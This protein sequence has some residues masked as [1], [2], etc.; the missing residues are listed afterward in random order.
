VLARSRQAARLG[1]TPLGRHGWAGAPR[2]APVASVPNP[3]TG[4]DLPV[5]ARK[6]PVGGRASPAICA[7]ESRTRRL[8]S[9]F[10]VGRVILGISSRQ[11]GLTKRHRATARTP[12]TDIVNG[13]APATQ[14]PRQ[15]TCSRGN[16]LERCGRTGRTKSRS[17]ARPGWAA[18]RSEVEVKRLLARNALS[19]QEQAGRLFAPSR[20]H[21][22]IP[23]FFDIRAIRPG[24]LMAL[25]PGSKMAIG[26]TAPEGGQ[27]EDDSERRSS[28]REPRRRGSPLGVSV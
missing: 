11:D 15:R 21:Q 22:I 5:R 7:N 19:R 4:L 25:R 28:G 26:R 8:R 2:S 16:P 1:G 3:P 10:D 20:L 27:Q 24:T 13:V 23:G 9:R 12:P 18:R 6:Q 17:P 14:N